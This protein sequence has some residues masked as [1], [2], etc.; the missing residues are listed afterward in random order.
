MMWMLNFVPDS[1]LL[2]VIDTVLISGAVGALLSFFLVGW[3][4]GI[5]RFKTLLQLISVALLVAGVYFKGGY[6]IEEEWRGKVRDLEAKLQ[7][8]ETKSKEVNTV[9]E[10][11]V[12]EKV[13]LVKQ[14]V[15]VIKKEIEVQ[16]VEIDKECKLT[17]KAKEIHNK[18]TISNIDGAINIHE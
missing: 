14:N 18:A 11:K 3:L 2:L 5:N 15:E 1:L 6:A 12:V 4:P 9:I 13:K 16:R 10:T 7:E 17:P 8:T